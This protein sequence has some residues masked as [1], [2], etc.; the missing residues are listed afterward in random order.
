MTAPVRRRPFLAAAAVAFATLLVA[1]P[2][3]CAQQRAVGAQA[4]PALAAEI[5][6]ADRALLRG[7]RTAAAQAAARIVRAVEGQQRPSSA[8]LVILGRAHVILGLGDAQA[9][10]DALAAFQAARAADPGNLEAELRT[11]DLFLDKYNAPEALA[12][13]RS[14][15]EARP[16]D[17][18]ALLGLARVEEFEGK[19]TALATVHKALA[20]NARHTDALVFA[21]RLYLEAEQYDSATAYATRAIATDSAS[22]PAWSLLGA[23]AWLG[24]DSATYA[25][26]RAAATAIQPRPVDFLVELAEAAVRNRRYAD[27]VTLASQA[28]GYDSTALRALGVLGTNQLRVGRMDEGRRTLDRAFALDPFNVWHKNTLDLLDQMRTFRTIERGRIQ[29][30]AP[31]A[32]AELLALYAIPLLERAFDSLRVR[33]GYAP[34]T[35]IRLEFFR[36]HADFSVRTVGLAGLGALGVSFGSLLAMDTPSAREQGA[37]NWGST[38]W[39]ELAHAFTLGASGHRVPRWLSEGLSVLE[40][41]RVG[42]GWGADASIPFL[43]ALARG[44]LRPMSTLSEGFLRPRHPDEIGFSYYQASL[45]CEMVEQTKGVAALRAMLTGYRDGLDTPGVFKRVLGATPEQVDAQFDA[46]VRRKFEAPLRAIAGGDAERGGAFLAAMQRGVAAM[47]AGQ[48]DSARVL[49][50]RAVG[51]FPD[52]AGID[53]PA[54]YLAR[55]EKERGNAAAALAHVTRVTSRNETAWEANLLE[56]ELRERQGDDAGTIAALERLVWIAPYDAALHARI[57]TLATKRGDHAL[58]V[59]ERRAIVATGPSDLLDARYELARALAA[60]GDVAGARKE[61]LGVLEQ[62]PSFEKAQALLLELRQRGGG[63]R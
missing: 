12:S 43:T 20:A 47:E 27:A 34:P 40:E 54:W 44:Q 46:W 8:D 7:D 38:A 11:G 2:R 16:N 61:L 18:D 42:Q 13:Y 5:A 52:Y 50:E 60:A 10:R 9:V 28:V 29:I 37:F 63:A 45:F 3:V 32:E 58:A 36:S 1:S 57:A 53:G 19:P 25:R 56:A 55:L 35:P 30:V 59:R 22:L 33:Y 6:T 31:P 17:A 41:R 62:A 26:A 21:S 14:V 24:G 23:T 39:H 4:T 48:R 51:M 15:L 49:F